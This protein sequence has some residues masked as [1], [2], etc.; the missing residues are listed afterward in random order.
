M[1]IEHW[2]YEEG[3][4]LLKKFLPQLQVDSVYDIDLEALWQAGRRGIITDLDNT[5]VG[6][7]VAQA[8]P[9]L[10]AWLQQTIDKGF[11][12]VVVSNNRKERVATFAQPLSLPYIHRAQKPRRSAFKRAL[13]QM[14]LTAEQVVV[15]GD[16]LLTDVFG[17][18]RLGAQTILVKAIALDQEEIVTRM[19]RRIERFILARMRHKLWE[20]QSS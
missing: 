7:E 4:V 3:D 14:N 19:N 11:R 16:Q 2:A 20:D 6:A 9:E 10:E 17:G 18:N 5:L 15:V 8:T 13:K 1:P 12:I